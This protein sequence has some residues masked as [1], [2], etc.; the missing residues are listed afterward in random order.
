MLQIVPRLLDA[1]V[2]ENKKAK[3]ASSGARHSAILTG[4]LLYYLL[5]LRYHRSTSSL[6][7]CKLTLNLGLYFFGKRSS[8]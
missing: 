4:K 8:S 2:L 5:V 6:S 1:S 3:M 7:N